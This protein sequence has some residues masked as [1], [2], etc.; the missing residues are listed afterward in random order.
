MNTVYAKRH[1]GEIPSRDD[2]QAPF[3]QVL[4]WALATAVVVALVD[5][6]VQ[7]AMARMIERQNPELTKA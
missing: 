6:A 4:L 2:V 1:E 5:V 7:Q 3:R